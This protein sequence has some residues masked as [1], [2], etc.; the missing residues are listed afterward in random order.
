MVAPRNPMP[1]AVNKRNDGDARPC[2]VTLPC[3]GESLFTRS[4]RVYPTVFKRSP[5][6]KERW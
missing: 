1:P 5:Y 4:L 3:G 2:S 6:K